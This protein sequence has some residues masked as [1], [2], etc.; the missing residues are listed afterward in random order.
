MLAKTSRSVSHN[1]IAIVPDVR[2]KL[3]LDSV[4]A[5][6][7]LPSASMPSLGILERLDSRNVINVEARHRNLNINAERVCNHL[8]GIHVALLLIPLAIDFISVGT[9][10]FPLMPRICTVLGD[11][12]ELPKLST[13]ES[14]RLEGIQLPGKCLPVNVNRVPQM[15]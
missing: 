8:V 7:S 6:F 10:V 14:S 5:F 13:S 1:N 12:E 11:E 15:F 9:L 2:R 4:G 3:F